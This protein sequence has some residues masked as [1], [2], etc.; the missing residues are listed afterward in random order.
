VQRGEALASIARMFNT[1]PEAL[2]SLNK[3]EGD[4]IRIGQVLIVKPFTKEPMKFPEGV[5]REDERK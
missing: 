3:I 2:R 4:R 1:T 5:V